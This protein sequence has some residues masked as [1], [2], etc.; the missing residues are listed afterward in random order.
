[1][2]KHQDSTLPT[3]SI[4]SKAVTVQGCA[5][6]ISITI[7]STTWGLVLIKLHSSQSIVFFFVSSLI[8]KIVR[9]QKPFIYR[10]PVSLFASVIVLITGSKL[11]SLNCFSC[12]FSHRFVYFVSLSERRNMRSGNWNIV[13]VRLHVPIHRRQL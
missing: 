1:M 8:S 11:F 12:V 6:L 7:F 9:C 10:Q 3:Y 13:P 2:G 5:I 4:N